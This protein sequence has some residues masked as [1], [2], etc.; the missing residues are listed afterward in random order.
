VHDPATL[1]VAFGR[2]AGNRGANTPG[3]DGLTA[4]WVEERIG[5]PGFLEDLR[6][7]LKAGTFRPLL[8]RERVI[9]KPGETDRQQY[10]HRAP[11]RLSQR[12]STAGGPLLSGRVESALLF[13]RALHR[14]GVS[15]RS[16]ANTHREAGQTQSDGVDVPQ[17]MQMRLR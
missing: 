9:P 1:I 15:W 11:G 16:R 4:A 3:V 14:V 13:I 8:V 7:A 5:V 2:A 6:A 10:R 12:W 17:V